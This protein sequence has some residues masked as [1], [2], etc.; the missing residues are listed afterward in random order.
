MLFVNQKQR[1]LAFGDGEVADEAF[2]ENHG[3]SILEDISQNVN[4]SPDWF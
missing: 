1:D 4:T 2:E 3:N